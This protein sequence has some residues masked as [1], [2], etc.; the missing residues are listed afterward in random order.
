[1]RAGR[2]VSSFSVQDERY[3]D[4]MDGGVALTPEQSKGR[5][6]WLLWTGGNDRFWDMPS[7]SYSF[8]AIDLLK[9]VSSYSSPA[10]KFSRDNRWY[11]LGLVNEPCFDKATGPDP[12][13]FGLWLDKRGPGLPARPVRRREEVSGRR[14]SARAAKR[15]RSA[16]ITATP[17]GIVGLR[18]FPNPDFDE[19]ARKEMGPEALL[20]RSG[21]LYVENLVRPYRVGMSCGVLPCRP[22][23]INPPA[24]PEN[25]E[26]G[27][28]ELDR[29]RAV[30]LGGPHLRLGSRTRELHL[31]D[32]AHLPARHA[33]HVARVDR[34]H[35]QSAHDE[36]AST[37]SVPRL[38][39]AKRW[40]RKRWPAAN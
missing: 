27:E 5:I 39:R 31:P 19:A 40:A 2:P 20:Q 9:T 14:A 36:R 12:Q 4:A 10:Y 16:P 22:N 25:P 33:R 15:C 7:R 29:R 38:A 30:F 18:L 8:G 26:M 37:S 6:N 23:P 21:L 35:Q 34:Q 17:T 3:F 28:P 24:D 11:Y 13:R 32:P 1:M